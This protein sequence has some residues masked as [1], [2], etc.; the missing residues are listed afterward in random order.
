MKKQHRLGLLALLLM[1]IVGVACAADEPE[2]AAPRPTSTSVAE[3]VSAKIYAL[4]NSSPHVTVID[5][6]TNQILQ[7]ADIPDL[8]R[9]AWNDD[10][11]YFDGVNLW[12]GL[13]YPGADDAQVIALNLDTLEVTERI[14]L[15]K[16]A[17]NLYIGKAARDGIIHVGMQGSGQVKTIDT[18]TFQV[19]DT[20]TPPVNGGVVCDADVATGSDG[21]ERFYYPTRQG[22][23]VVSLDAK[24]GETLVV[25][26]IPKGSTP[27]MHT[28]APDGRVWV[29][30]SGSHT[31]AVFDPITLDL[32]KR[33]PAGQV[34]V[35]A[36]FSPDGRYA[37][38]GHSKDPVVQVVDTDTLEEVTR[39]TAGAT[40]SK[41]AVHPN[42]KYIYAIVSKEAAVAVIDTA[43]WEV[44]ERVDIGT[45]PGGLYL[46]AS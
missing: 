11:N 42:G 35:V 23:T 44:T 25:V 26:E 4:S 7:T 5:A 10:N 18:R 36:S 41:V 29:Q 33:F 8:T 6:E 39:I 40:P 32:I 17:A 45:N 21:V 24:T 28:N 12:L 19:L 22:D 37:Y 20:W 9:W 16:E 15:G 2:A 31:N 3:V 30:E 13:K 38:I 1:A 43:T 46:R 14:L 27:L 34:P